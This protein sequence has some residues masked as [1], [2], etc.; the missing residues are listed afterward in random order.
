VPELFA[1][2]CSIAP[3]RRR[4]FLWAAWWSGSPTRDPFRKPDAF[5]GGAR[6]REEALAKAERAAGMHLVEIEPRWARAWGRVL[7]GQPP[8]LEKKAPDEGGAHSPPAERAARSEGEAPRPSIWTTLR[9]TSHVSAAELK[10]A[11]RARALETHP[12]R[13]GTAESFREVQRAYEEA[14]RRIARPRKKA[15]KKTR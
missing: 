8:W 7:V 5:E 2:V 6:T 9:V 3:T 15:P 12:D 13:G 1:A 14:Q 11:F 4:R 10:S